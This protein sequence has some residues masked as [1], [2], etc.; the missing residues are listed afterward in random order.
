[1]DLGLRGKNAI[2]T[3]GTGS[4]GFGISEVLAEEGANIIIVHRHD[5]EERT[6]KV[7]ELAERT[8]VSVKTYVCD[9]S[10]EE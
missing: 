10:K 8:G 9:L 5:T 2:V 1:M 3:G 6:A 7:K 4:L